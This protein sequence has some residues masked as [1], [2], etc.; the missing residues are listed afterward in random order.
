MRKMKW[1]NR[2]KTT[3]YLLPPLPQGIPTT[4]FPPA[5]L[6][7]Q[8]C[9]AHLVWKVTFERRDLTANQSPERN[10]KRSPDPSWVLSASPCFLK[11]HS[12]PEFAVAPRVWDTVGILAKTYIKM[13]LNSLTQEPKLARP[14][15]ILFPPRSICAS[16]GGR[17]WAA[18]RT[19]YQSCPPW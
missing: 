17:S 8:H 15:W 6:P 18:M 12:A 3:V 9:L 13:A 16:A 11:L 10:P 4:P 2:K 1:W 19:V 5:G 14:P 7:T